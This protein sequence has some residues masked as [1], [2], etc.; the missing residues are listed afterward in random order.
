MAGRTIAESTYLVGQRQAK[1][2]YMDRI[3]VDDIYEVQVRAV[4]H[5]H[6]VNEDVFPITPRDVKDWMIRRSHE[7]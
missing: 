5:R 2:K 6:A 3:G 4:L 1:V 7:I